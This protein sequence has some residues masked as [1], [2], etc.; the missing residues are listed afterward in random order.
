MSPESTERPKSAAELQYEKRYVSE[1]TAIIRDQKHADLGEP[2]EID[3]TKIFVD[4][5]L[6]SADSGE[7][8]LGGE[9][10]DSEQM[11]LQFTTFLAER[12]QSLDPKNTQKLR[13]FTNIPR[14]GGMRDAFEALMNSSLSDKLIRTLH[15]RTGIPIVEKEADLTTIEDIQERGNVAL[16]AVGTV[17]PIPDESPY[18]KALNAASGIIDAVPPHILNPPKAVASVPLPAPM[19]APE[20]RQDVVEPIEP[21]KAAEVVLSPQAQEQLAMYERFDRE[22]KEELDELYKDIRAMDAKPA[23][24]R[25][26]DH[27]NERD[28]LA[29]E[30]SYKKSERGKYSHKADLL[31]GHKNVTRGG[32]Y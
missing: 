32:S 23:Y 11:I 25:G 14:D 4:R 2:D 5:L 30:I 17:E 8:K 28:R 24:M 10:I 26:P 12:A 20:A 27:A 22:F 15:E 19:P 18:D 6:H 21:A 3:R 1:A 29:R 16:D 13:P 9:A 7:V 31:K